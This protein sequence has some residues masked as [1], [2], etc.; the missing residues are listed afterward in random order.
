MSRTERRG[1]ASS[2]HLLNCIDHIP[3][4]APRSILSNTPPL[5]VL[6]SYDTVKIR[7]NEGTS[8][9]IGTIYSIS[10][11]FI[12]RRHLSFIAVGDVHLLYCMCYPEDISIYICTQFLVSFVNRTH[13]IVVVAVGQPCRRQHHVQPQ[14]EIKCVYF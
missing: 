2:I 7:S 13:R 8:T 5:S 4:R 3:P 10:E 6:Q 12:L 11:Y 1:L 14:T 9:Y